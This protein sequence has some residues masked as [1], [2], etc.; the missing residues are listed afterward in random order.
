M[1][2]YA[3]ENGKAIHGNVAA[4]RGLAE[5]GLTSGTLSYPKPAAVNDRQIDDQG[6]NLLSAV[7]HAVAGTVANRAAVV[8]PK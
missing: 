5:C 1:V 2:L 7:G 3:M 4:E 8:E 6:D